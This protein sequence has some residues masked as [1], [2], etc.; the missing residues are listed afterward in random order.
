MDR[1]AEIAQLRHELDILRSRLALYE[2]WGRIVRI[3]IMIWTPLFATVII[4]GLVKVFQFDVLMGGFFVALAAVIGLAAWLIR[5]W[6]RPR[7]SKGRS[8]W[9]DIV[10]PPMGPRSFAAGI[11]AFTFYGL[12]R[13]RRNDAEI[14][15][16]QIAEREHRLK[17][18]G[19]P[20]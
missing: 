18:L 11:P 16:D 10:A 5:G 20:S 8:W 9:T 15:E 1:E 19:V 4:F 2:R 3:F 6:G 12:G 7:P 13:R 17:E 14:I